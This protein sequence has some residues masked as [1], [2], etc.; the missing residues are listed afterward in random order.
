MGSS[1][2]EECDN[3]YILP[4]SSNNKVEN[5][6]YRLANRDTIHSVFSLSTSLVTTSYSTYCN[7]I[8]TDNSRSIVSPGRG[9]G[10][11]VP[12]YFQSLR[13][14][15]S[16]ILV[17]KRNINR[18]TLEK[19]ER[20]DIVVPRYPSRV[21]YFCMVGGQTLEKTKQTCFVRLEKGR[22]T[23]SVSEKNPSWNAAG[24]KFL[25]KILLWGN[26]LLRGR[27]GCLVFSR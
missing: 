12:W 20:L 1:S 24:I 10:T 14:R 11:T 4:S 27:T 5:I 6:V 17:P 23:I 3:R 16:P 18:N 26:L 22:A 7:R 2:F 8:N 21:V 15:T 13:Y 19:D 9:V 25:L